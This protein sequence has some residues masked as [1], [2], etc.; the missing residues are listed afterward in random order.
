M[1][2]MGS[3][4]AMLTN[5]LGELL[6]SEV[7]KADRFIDLFAGSGAVSIHVA[8]R[9]SIPV[10]SVD[11]Q[12]YSSILT[13]A[14]VNRKSSVNHAKV[15]TAWYR[16]AKAIANKFDPPDPFKLTK[17]TVKDAR[18]W[19]SEQENTLVVG[20]YGGHYFS[21]KQAVWLDA[22][23]STL[24][25]RDPER[26]VALAALI[27][28]ASQCAAAPGH[29][30][31][32]FQPTKTAK[33][34]LDDAWN[35]DVIQ[36]TKDSLISTSHLFAKQIG[37]SFVGDAIKLAA[38]LEKGDLV[39]IDPPYSA[40]QY[41]RFYHVLET[42]AQGH[43]GE[44]T[45]IG[46]YPGTHLR[47]RSRFSLKTESREAL[48]ELLKEISS[49]G[50]RAILTFPDH[51]CSNGLSGDSVRQIASKYFRLY[52]QSVASKFSTLGGTGIDTDDPVA[53]RA[54]RHHANELILLLAPK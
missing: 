23:R 54:A 47:P 30:A 16:R 12:Q 1:K 7:V 27:Q 34:F 8:Q 53:S 25:K 18:A 10:V 28:A 6:N 36:R 32:P 21:P 13:R 22:L 15:W 49:R 50:A 43:C 19:C 9:F 46:R 20:A 38:G 24:P 45:G 11:L 35:R 14:V 33:R 44:V 29:T 26:T 3:K 4:R 52:E 39:F 31:Q 48:D 51:R 37:A 17:Q 5:G 41:S 42:I 2:Y 40:V